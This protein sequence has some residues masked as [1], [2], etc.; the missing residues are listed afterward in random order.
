MGVSIGGHFTWRELIFFS[1][2]SMCMMIFMS[3]YCIV[4][5]FFVSRVV[6]SEALSALNIVYPMIN[7]II[8][9]GL[10]LGAGGNA[11]VSRAMGEGD[12]DRANRYFTF[13]VSQ[14][15]VFGGIIFAMAYFFNEELCRFLGADATLMENAKIY[16]LMTSMFAPATMLQ[17]IFQSFFVTASRPKLGMYLILIAGVTNIILDYVFMVDMG[18]GIL[19]AAL[20][21]GLGQMIPAITGLLFFP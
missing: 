7:L 11:I 14:A 12:Q 4:D 1:L 13:L 9:I 17:S 10:M 3:L 16:L 20:G 21:T 8:A 2:P 19:G 18:L 6:G 15:F 5:G